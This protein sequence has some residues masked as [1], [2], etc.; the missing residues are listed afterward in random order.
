[1]WGI[2]WGERGR[3]TTALVVAA[4]VAAVGLWDETKASATTFCV[5]E[6]TA[7]CPNAGGNV[8]IAEIEPAM[9]AQSADGKADEIVVAPGSFVDGAGFEPAGG[10]V[11]VFE[12]SGSDPLTITGAGAGQTALTSGL[13]GNG[14]LV[15]LAF[16]NTREVTIRDL[17]ILVPAVYEDDAG[18]GIQ[19]SGDV[20]EGVNVVSANPGSDGILAL[21]AGNVVRGGEVRAEGAGSIDH[22]IGMISV[23][24]T[25]LVEDELVDGA[26]WAILSESKGSEIVARRVKVVDAG[27]YGAVAYPGRV[28]LENST[29]TID[30]GIGLFAA[31]DASPATLTADHVTVVN[32]SDSYP[33]LEGKKFSPSVG[34]AKISVS[35]S[36]FRGFA[37]G[38]KIET[39]FGPGVGT[40]SIDARYSNIKSAGTNANGK[41]DLSVGNIEADPLLGADLSLQPGSPSI[42]AGDPAVGGLDED[43]L[44]APRPVDGDGDCAARR[45]QGAFEYQLPPPPACLPPGP[46]DRSG[47]ANDATPP[48]TRIKAGPGK[49]LATGVAKFRFASSE[50][51]S[52]FRCRLDRHKARRCRSPKRFGKLRPGRHVFRVWATDAAGNKDPTPARR[53]FRVPR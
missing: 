36:V 5:P 52:T 38:Y 45:D 1:M 20:L 14:Y 15:N 7:A 44:G 49:R 34:S 42:D 16:S 17:T 3:T 31:A 28:T 41:V 53:R 33:A 48:Q 32:S 25:L 35:N 2:A 51:G 29:F 21:E 37:S 9:A 26:S 50:P 12:P 10:T 39:P 18:A 19:M 47:D 43:F 27:A 8:A 46:P 23:S 4:M 22:G 40:V 30:D 24:G 11:G 6:F 13:P